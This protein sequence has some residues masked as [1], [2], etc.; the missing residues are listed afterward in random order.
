MPLEHRQIMQ[1]VIGYTIVNDL[2]IHTFSPEQKKLIED[3]MKKYSK[4]SDAVFKFDDVKA[5][6]IDKFK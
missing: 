3:R 4:K 2:K 5:L 1:E 6:V